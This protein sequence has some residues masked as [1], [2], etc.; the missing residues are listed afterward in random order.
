MIDRAFEKHYTIAQLSELWNCSKETM[1][2]LVRLEDDVLKLVGPN[3]KVGYRI[4]ESV[5]RR[6]HAKLIEPSDK[7]GHFTVSL[8][9]TTTRKGDRH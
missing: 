5:A 7:H 4:P 8:S 3:G 2:R 6:I 9:S 1:R